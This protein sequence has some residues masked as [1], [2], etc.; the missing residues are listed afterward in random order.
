MAS[1]ICCCVA[2]ADGA[3]VECCSLSNATTA[4]APSPSTM[5]ALILT[6]SRL[7]SI[8]MR[9]RSLRSAPSSDRS[10]MAEHVQAERGAVSSAVRGVR[11]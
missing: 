1:R 11:W 9:R 5:M 3:A 6:M 4:R 7:C 8:H 10:I 2:V